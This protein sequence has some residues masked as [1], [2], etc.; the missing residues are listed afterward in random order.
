MAAVL[1]NPNTWRLDPPGDYVA[2]RAATLEARM[3]DVDR[4][5]LAVCVLDPA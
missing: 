3:R 2:G 4:D 1:P 5:G